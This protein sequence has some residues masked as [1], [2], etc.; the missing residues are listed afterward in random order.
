MRGLTTHCRRDPQNPKGDKT[1]GLGLLSA[2]VPGRSEQSGRCGG[3]LVTAPQGWEAV[4]LSCSNQR[5]APVTKR[6][7]TRT[8]QE[9][10]AHALHHILSSDTC[11][12]H[13]SATARRNSSDTL[14]TYVTSSCAR[15]FAAVSF[16]LVH[17]LPDRPPWCATAQVRFIPQEVVCLSCS[18]QRSAP[19]TKSHAT[20]TT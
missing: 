15:G 13:T 16:K 6:H 7:A 3:S 11:T 14:S 4:C 19:V 5:S 17:H 9:T 18:N 2:W 1:K 12:P 8:T 10:S 20:R